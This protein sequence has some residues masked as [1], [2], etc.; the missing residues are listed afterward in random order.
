MGMQNEIAIQC[1]PV[2]NAGDPTPAPNSMNNNP[3]GMPFPGSFGPYSPLGMLNSPFQQSPRI[4]AP[5]VFEDANSMQ[6]PNGMPYP[7]MGPQGNWGGQTNWG[8]PQFQAPKFSFGPPGGGT[9][10]TAAPPAWARNEKPPLTI[11]SNRGPPL[12][13]ATRRLQPTRQRIQSKDVVVETQ[14]G[15]VD[16]TGQRV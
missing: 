10:T 12:M 1:G 14:D 3:M 8:T 16:N 13:T 5:P 4:P 7:G 2:R 11:A 15:G 9:T 6:P